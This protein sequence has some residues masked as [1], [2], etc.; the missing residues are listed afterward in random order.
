MS[1][2]NA[3]AETR[4]E[5]GHPASRS[6]Q[7]TP[8]F[9]PL[10]AISRPGGSAV[11]VSGFRRFHQARLCGINELPVL[12]VPFDGTA[13]QE[14][15][16]VLGRSHQTAPD[17]IL[18]GWIL[19]LSTVSPVDHSPMEIAGLIS[20]AARDLRC[21]IRIAAALCPAASDNENARSILTLAE[22]P[23]AVLKRWHRWGIDTNKA[24]LLCRYAPKE[25]PSATLV[26]CRLLHL[27]VSRM[28]KFE[29]LIR[30]IALRERRSVLK[31]L[32]EIEKEL[33]SRSGTEDTSAQIGECCLND[34]EIRRSPAKHRML[35]RFKH[36][37]S[38]LD[39]VGNLSI[40]PPPDF[41]G[42]FVD[43]RFKLHSMNELAAAVEILT[44][45]TETWRRLIHLVQMEEDAIQ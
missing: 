16:S 19:A 42:D 24:A 34:L 10:K 25:R 17:W 18:T 32:K 14:A 12:V 22:M 43:I 26:T 28:R 5:F 3:E 41:E 39:G 11:L 37:V 13:A 45:Q 15:C 30:D 8:F 4:Y 6:N 2:D 1:F 35:D 23:S 38:Q 7:S 27:T 44:E 29:S 36:A 9:E 31:V 20:R 40:S 33:I 21:S